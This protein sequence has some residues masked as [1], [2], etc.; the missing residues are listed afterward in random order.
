MRLRDTKNSVLALYYIYAAYEINPVHWMTSGQNDKKFRLEVY[1]GGKAC[2]HFYYYDQN[3]LKAD[4]D[5]IG[6][7]VEAREMGGEPEG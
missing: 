3:H 6:R 5:F 7:W 4:L 2:Q 1:S